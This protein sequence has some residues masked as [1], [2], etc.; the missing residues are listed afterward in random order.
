M[1]MQ[2]DSVS[3]L[4]PL[5]TLLFIRQIIYEYGHPGWNDSDRG[6]SKNAEVNLS[7]YHFVHHKFHMDWPGT[8]P[9]PILK[10]NYKKVKQSHN[11]PMAA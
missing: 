11:T 9:V 2:W 10:L 5:A 6:N 8:E 7:K 3:E 4:Q 1:S